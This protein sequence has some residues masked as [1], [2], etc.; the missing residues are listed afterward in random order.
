MVNDMRNQISSDSNKRN[1]FRRSGKLRG[2]GGFTLAE[3]LIVIAIIL[4]LAAFGFVNVVQNQRK[5]RLREMDD[6]ARQIFI[7]AQNHLTV[8]EASGQW[9]Y[10]KLK[11]D[12][13]IIGPHN[14][15]YTVYELIGESA[16]GPATDKKHDYRVIT[17]NTG[18]ANGSAIDT[19]LP[20]GAIDETL[21]GNRFIILYDAKT[22]TINGVYYS[23]YDGDLNFEN[24]TNNIYTRYIYPT[25]NRGGRLASAATRLIGWYGPGE[26][27]GVD[28]NG[29]KRP[30]VTVEN[31]EAL[32]LNIVDPNNKL[33]T[34]PKAD[35]SKQIKLVFKGKT[36]GTAEFI[37]PIDESGHFNSDNFAKNV[38]SQSSLNDKLNHLWTGKMNANNWYYKIYLDSINVPG[39]HFAEIFESS[40][41]IAG[42]DITISVSVIFN[43]KES[44]ATEVTTNSLFG[45]VSES[46][47]MVLNGRHLQNLDSEISNVGKA[48]SNPIAITGADIR[49]DIAWRDGEDSKDFENN[50]KN[51][52]KTGTD[53]FSLYTGSESTAVQVYKYNNSTPKPEHK[54]YSI[55]NATLKTVNGNENTLSNFDIVENDTDKNA[56]LFGSFAVT[57]SEISDLKLKN[58]TVTGTGSAGALCGFS[59]N[60]EITKVLAYHEAQTGPTYVPGKDSLI[61]GKVSGGLVGTMDGGKIEQS[62]AAVF[63]KATGTAAA[64]NA[65]GLVGTCTGTVNITDSYTGGHTAGYTGSDID[66]IGYYEDVTT[67]GVRGRYNVISAGGSA[68]GLIGSYAGGTII[69]CYSTASASGTSA[70]GGLI[71]TATNPVTATN[72]YCTGRVGGSAADNHKG[73]FMGTGSLAAGSTGNLYFSI[74]NNDMKAIG[75]V[76]TETTGLSALDANLTT[77]NDF[78][79]IGKTGTAVAEAK[80]YDGG[81]TTLYDGKYALKTISQ[82]GGPSPTPTAPDTIPEWL[83]THYGDWAAPETF[84]VNVSAGS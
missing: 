14:D 70:A 80:P 76:E 19:I 71:G 78:V 55:E 58:F 74:V 4:I 59:K 54:F 32:S 84:V 60:T 25:D 45:S 51:I 15:L 24:V 61:T 67:D 37:V 48:A 34:N 62:A 64:D 33:V 83:T 41:F 73:Q 40:G 1:D 65:G 31:L 43:G 50:Y 39:G 29:L 49:S 35:E 26:A 30:I 75:G 77:Y 17:A 20:F 9:D 47:A 12:A 16:E 42:D 6:I 81:L 28:D 79:S 23:E 66:L 11:N 68:G 63:V 7:A 18:T 44:K 46:N 56:G 36:A 10:E 21:K 72:S 38:A 82:L 22:A 2:H 53:D 52:G 69:R 57:D 8:A 3:L 13:S 5:L 27:E